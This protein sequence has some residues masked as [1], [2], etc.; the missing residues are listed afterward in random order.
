MT[1]VPRDFEVAARTE[2]GLVMALRHRHWPMVGVQ[3]HPDS[4]LTEHGTEILRNVL[5]ERY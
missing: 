2:A 1:E 3:F 5:H 4:F